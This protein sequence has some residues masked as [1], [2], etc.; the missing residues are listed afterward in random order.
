MLTF[1]S[2]GEMLIVRVTMRS[3]LVTV[4][5]AGMVALLPT[6]IVAAAPQNE[7]IFQL[8]V[9]ELTNAERVNAGLEPLALS[10]ELTDAAQSYSEVLAV[11]GCFE[12]TCGPVP[13][14]ADRVGLAGYVGWRALAENIAA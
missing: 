14:F 11:S 4:V 1:A 3:F 8:R 7:V 10:Y 5:L 9:L 2:V 12:H 6:A 13:H